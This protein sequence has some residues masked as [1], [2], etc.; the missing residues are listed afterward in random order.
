MLEWECIDLGV[1]AAFRTTFHQVIHLAHMQSLGCMYM[2]LRY[3]GV[4]VE[5]RI[6]IVFCYGF[7]IRKEVRNS[8][9][10]KH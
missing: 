3:L 5:Q 4:Y 9:C 7:I 10:I 8:K 6:L 2:V 1:G